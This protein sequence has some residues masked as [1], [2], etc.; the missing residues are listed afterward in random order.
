MALVDDLRGICEEYSSTRWD[1]TDGRTVPDPEDLTHANTGRWLDATVLYADI[2]GSTLMVDSLAPTLAA[3]YYKSYLRCASMILTDSGGVITAY[4]GD[5][6]M[7]VFLGE[8]KTSLA[9]E[10]ALKISGMMLRILNPT[11]ETCYGELH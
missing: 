1:F 7:S 4:D 9:L 11:F 6:V 5:R 2:D 8:G 10:A 3:E